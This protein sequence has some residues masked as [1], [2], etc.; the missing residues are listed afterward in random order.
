MVHSVE[1]L[2]LEGAGIVDGKGPTIPG[3][4]DEPKDEVGVAFWEIPVRVGHSATHRVHGEGRFPLAQN[5]AGPM[6]R[7]AG[8]G[9]PD[10]P[11][12]PGAHEDRKGPMGA[13]RS[14][15]AR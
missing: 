12:E 15:A 13:L 1:N 6:S 10:E 7:L 2:A 3:A 5:L 8:E 11:I 14:S 4:L 9:F